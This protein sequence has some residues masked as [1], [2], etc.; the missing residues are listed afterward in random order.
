[1]DKKINKTIEDY[2]VSFKD[3]L[4]QKILKLELGKGDGTATTAK[5]N[6]FLEYLNEYE[7]LVIDKEEFVKK[8]RPLPVIPSENRCNGILQ[9]SEQCAR[10]KLPN[11]HYC[12][13][14]CK[15]LPY[16]SLSNDSVENTQVVVFETSIQ[17][18][19]YYV[20]EF[21]NI[22]KTEDIL[23][24]VKNPEIVAHLSKVTVDG[25]VRLEIG[26]L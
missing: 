3:A 16:G 17:G 19:I 22:Y 23:N 4:K 18:I 24:G 15:K 9:N 10:R 5:V 6:D 13:S 25:D 8:T 21:D 14:H 11:L 12:G 1:M 26:I 20:D 2:I 7:K